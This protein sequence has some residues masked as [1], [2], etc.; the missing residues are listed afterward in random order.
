V[1]TVFLVWPQNQGRRFLGLGLKTSI[2][3]LVI[4]V[5]KS[6]RQFFGLVSKLSELW[7]IGCTSKSTVGCDGVGHT[8]RSGGLFC[9]EASHARVSQSDL[10]TG[11]GTSTG[12]ARGIIME[13]ASREN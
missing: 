8:S 13:V 4:W 6:S 3:G 10:K 5:S 9:L 2:C 12:G 1:A 11:G 7:F